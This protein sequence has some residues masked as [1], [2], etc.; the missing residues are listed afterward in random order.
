M[1]F[2]IVGEPTAFCEVDTSIAGITELLGA[3]IRYGIRWALESEEHLQ[4]LLSRYDVRG[5]HYREEDPDVWTPPP[6]EL[7]RYAGQVIGAD[8]EDDT[9]YEAT[10]QVIR[11]LLDVL[12][13]TTL[14]GIYAALRMPMGDLASLLAALKV[15]GLLAPLPAAGCITQPRPP[16]GMAHA[17][18]RIRGRV[19]DRAADTGMHRPPDSFYPSGENFCQPATIPADF[20]RPELAGIAELVRAMARINVRDGRA[21]TDLAHALAV[22]CSSTDRWSLEDDPQTISTW[23]VLAERFGDGQITCSI[24]SAATAW[25]ACHALAGHDARVQVGRSGDGRRLAGVTFVTGPD[26]LPITP[27]ELPPL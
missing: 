27:E 17:W 6:V 26:S 5:W 1:Y 7:V 4:A 25:A 18:S 14:A 20:V 23:S 13:V 22:A 19:V 3:G 15:R 11:A 24:Y 8:C 16:H 12:R 2:E 10:Y 21:D 9:M